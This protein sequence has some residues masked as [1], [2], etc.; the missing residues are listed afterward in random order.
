MLCEKCGKNNATVMYTQIVNGQKSSLNI[1]SACAS[2][3]SIFDK[4]CSGCLAQYASSK[5]TPKKKWE[6]VTSTLAE[7]D[8]S[9]I[10]YVKVPDNHIVIDFDIPDETVRKALKRI[11]KRLV[12]GRLRTPNYRRVVMVFTYIIFTTVML[13]N[14][15]ECMQTV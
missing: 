6:E 14:L 7:I 4:E 10:H 9:K 12:N 3:E 2:Q 11:W 8:T 5:E 13:L 1:C 15:V